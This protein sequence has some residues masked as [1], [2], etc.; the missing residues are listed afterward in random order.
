MILPGHLGL[1]GEIRGEGALARTVTLVL[2]EVQAKRKQGTLL[3][4]SFVDCHATMGAMERANR[5]LRELL[6]SMSSGNEAVAWQVRCG[7]A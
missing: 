3:E 7:L 4:R 5:T 6:P 2:R 1:V